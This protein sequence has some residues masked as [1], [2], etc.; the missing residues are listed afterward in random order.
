MN[1]ALYNT[2]IKE[3]FNVSDRRQRQI[4]LALNESDQDTVMMSLSAKL[5][6]CIV[7]RVADIDYDRIPDS[8]GDITKIPN[9]FELVE[10][11]QTIHDLLVEYK[12]PTD[13]TDTVLEAIENL[14]DSQKLWEKAFATECGFPMVTYNTI[15]LSIVSSVSFLIA[16]SIEF[17]KDPV[18]NNFN[19]ALDKAGYSKSKNSL[20][21]K[22]LAKFN[23]SYKKGDVTKAMETLIKANNQVK[24]KTNESS[25][26]EEIEEVSVGA[27]AAGISLTA[28]VIAMI[29]CLV[30]LLQEL[31]C[32]LYCARQNVADYFEI[33]S[34]VVRLN[35]ENVKLDS[36]KTPAER[37]KIYKKQVAIADKFKKIS[38]TLTIKFKS[39]E[40]K[41][42][43][44][45][46][47]DN[48]KKYDVED[49]VSTMPQSAS[50]IF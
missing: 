44:L 15:A 40:K 48:K 9:Y 32:M 37:D 7:K 5:Y 18:Q 49:V 10:C 6:D 38:N 22:N 11:V 30:P 16:A 43:A 19:L 12:Q 31:V 4:L 33:Q 39:S 28:S 20:L 36:T 46:K 21:F 35:A 45:V 27:I 8:K 14:K 41:A 29:T 26:M 47:E 3:H 23:K 25:S 42:E 13:A 2:L 34:S 17:I 1:R 50:G 24:V